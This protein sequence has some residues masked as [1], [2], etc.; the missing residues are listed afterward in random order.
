MTD[1]QTDRSVF[2]VREGEGYGEGLTKESIFGA[3][4][5]LEEGEGV[6]ISEFQG[7][8]TVRVV[9][10][11]ADQVRNVIATLLGQDPT[12]ASNVITT[13]EEEQRAHSKRADRLQ[14]LEG[15]SEKD[16]LFG[17]YKLEIFGL[18]LTVWVQ[19]A[20]DADPERIKILLRNNVP[21][22]EPQNFAVLAF[23]K[24]TGMVTISE[25]EAELVGPLNEVCNFP[26]EILDALIA[27]MT[28]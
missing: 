7:E 6:E 2:I 25:E 23:N 20:K 11:L 1:R 4:K 3:L 26:S 17:R 24:R 19:K 27:Q 18:D 13:T 8:L 21:D 5:G 12:D 10:K 16:G 14:A 15:L 9:K 28:S 22:G